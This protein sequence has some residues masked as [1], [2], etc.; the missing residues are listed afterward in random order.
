MIKK[1]SA[2]VS[3]ELNS[4]PSKD[5]DDFVGIEAHIEKMNL[6]LCKESNE[7]K[8]IGIWGPAGIGKS[9]IARALYNRLSSNFQVT[10]FMENV[11]GSYRSNEINSSKLRLQER[12]LS[13]LFNDKD[14]RIT[15]LGVAENRLRYWK[16][17][18]VLDDVDNIE[19]LNAVADRPQWFGD[20]S[21][22]IV[23]TEHKDILEAHDINSIYEVGFPSRLEALQ[24][25]SQSAFRQDSPADGYVELAN[26]VAKLTNLPLGLSVLGSSLRGK[27]KT[28]WIRALPSLKATLHEDIERILRIGYDSLGDND[29]LK[30]IFLYIACLFNG[31]KM[32]RVTRF[33]E[34]SDLDIESGLDVLVERAL[35]SISSD[36]RI[37]MHNLL[38]QMGQQIVRRQSTHEPGKRQF[39]VDAKKINDVLADNTVSPCLYH[40]I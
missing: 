36:K 17:L 39:L 34:N 31:D 30:A 22:I 15:N 4:T 14:L 20:G 1:I 35:I 3:N 12:F 23:T 5:F 11:K 19:Q 37:M 21:R 32:D 40:L 10:L 9:T 26:E 7:V 29:H 18:I 38:R 24:I 13:E 6:L 2:D 27:S 8:M 16:V 25:F 33:L 28:K